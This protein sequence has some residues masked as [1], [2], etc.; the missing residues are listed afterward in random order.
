MAWKECVICGAG[1]D[2]RGSSK[3]CSKDCSSINNKRT[4]KTT[5]QKRSGKITRKCLI[6][7]EY[8]TVYAGPQKTCSSDCR[9]IKNSQYRKRHRI[10]NPE[11]TAIAKARDYKKNKHKHT[12]RKRN[13]LNKNPHKKKHYY[14]SDVPKK[15]SH[16]LKSQLGTEPPADLVE[17]ATALRLLNRALREKETQ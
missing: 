8:F 5:N 10:E 9:D 11:M 13:W 15:V 2:A 7:D 6:C 3:T 1:F 4:Q 14:F 17:E 12:I 16:Y